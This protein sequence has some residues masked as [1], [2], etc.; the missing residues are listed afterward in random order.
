MTKTHNY[1][2]PVTNIPWEKDTDSFFEQVTRDG[3]V[4]SIDIDD[5]LAAFI[6]YMEERYGTP[7]EGSMASGSLEVMW[8][9]VNWSAA[10][11]N[12]EMC[13]D[14]P[15]MELAKEMVEELDCQVPIAY[16]SA[17]PNN[18]NYITFEWL[19][20]HNFPPAPVACLGRDLK[21]G[22]LRSGMFKLIIDD[23][24]SAMK[25]ARDIKVKRYCVAQP[26]NEDEEY[27][28]TIQEITNDLCS[29]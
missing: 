11:K 4:V 1:F 2:F 26:W 6:P 29:L 27:R 22:F 15:V 13:F 18:L 28:M 5:T 17:R 10:L 21:K 12:E 25:I 20:W 8:P 24:P 16:I 3:G 23:N 9:Y 19:D 14:I 7:V